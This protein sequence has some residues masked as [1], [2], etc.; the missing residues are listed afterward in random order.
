MVIPLCAKRKLYSHNA[1]YDVLNSRRGMSAQ[2]VDYDFSDCCPRCRGSF[3]ES[4]G[5][6]AGLKPEDDNYYCQR[7]AYELEF[8]DIPGPVEPSIFEKVTDK[9]SK[10]LK[11]ECGDSSGAIGECVE[12]RPGQLIGANASAEENRGQRFA[13][14]LMAAPS[15]PR[16]CLKCGHTADD[17]RRR[18]SD[19]YNSFCIY[20]CGCACV[21]EA[22]T[23]EQQA[24]IQRMIDEAI[25]SAL[26]LV[27]SSIE[28]ATEKLRSQTSVAIHRLGMDDS[29]SERAHNRALTALDK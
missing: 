19:E 10:F 14:K 9:I 24:L 18:G 6:P 3:E 15:K 5:K 20:G 8:L 28:E 4:G 1:E 17:K 23:P 25:R 27:D 13:H 7:C 21:F 2:P 22:F 26:V 16:P 29:I 11:L 12:T